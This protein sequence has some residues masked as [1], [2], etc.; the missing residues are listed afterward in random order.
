MSLRQLDER[1]WLLLCE[2]EGDKRFFERLILFRKI[3]D[4]FQIYFS[5]RT[6]TEKTGGRSRFGTWLAD[7]WQLDEGFRK[8]IK[9]V[10]IVSDNDQSQEKSFEEVKSALKDSMG[11]PIPDKPKDAARRDGFPPVVIFMLPDGESGSLETLCE[12]AALHK[13]SHL[14]YP[15]DTYIGNTPVKD[16][17]AGK[18]SKMRMQTIIAS[19]CMARPETGFLGHWN[20]NV[21]YHIPLDHEVF[22]SLESF[23][24][25]FMDF[26]I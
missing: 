24:R 18:Q 14:K 25:D 4:E 16:W 6:P 12:T 11:F 15:L 8:N 5:G 1:P 23:L 19:T 20:E 26:V 22:N 2:G 13:W 10:L 21:E 7:R 3:P 17:D 9:G